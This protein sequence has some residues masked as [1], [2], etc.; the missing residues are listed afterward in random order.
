MKSKGIKILSVLMAT[1]SAFSLCACNATLFETE[2]TTE[3]VFT[4]TPI[5]GEREKALEYFNTA[6]NSLKKDFEQFKR[7]DSGEQTATRPVISYKFEKSASKFDCEDKVLEANLSGLADKILENMNSEKPKSKGDYNP[8]MVDENGNKVDPDYKMLNELL[9][10]KNQDWVSKLTI[11][12]IK[13][14]QWIDHKKEKSKVVVRLGEEENPVVGEGIYGKIFNIG[15]KKAILDTFKGAESYF[16]V[17]DYSTKYHDGLIIC[18]I[19]KET[20]RV[21]ALDYT[22]SVTV[23]ADGEGAGNLASIGKQTITFEYN[24]TYELKFNYDAI[25]GVTAA[26]T[27]KK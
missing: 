14:I 19:D 13:D 18:T 4:T 15:D 6:V 20:D 7:E 25:D 23:T 11:D 21:L 1:V 12:D 8:E 22:K 3:K 9:P 26:E 5:V 16:K 27:T 24:E 2:T 17:N 10:V